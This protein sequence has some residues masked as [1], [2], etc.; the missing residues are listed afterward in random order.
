MNR[1][2]RN[3]IPSRLGIY[4]SLTLCLFL[5]SFLAAEDSFNFI[6]TADMRQYAG[7]EYDTSDY[8]LGVC[9]AIRG[10]GKGAFMVSPGDIDPPQGVR[11]TL[12]KV[13]G[14]DYLWY[15]VVGNHEAETPADMTWLREW[16]R[17]DIPNLVR[18]GPQNG[19]ETTY[20]F[21][22]GQVH[23]VVLNQYYDGSS[24]VGTNGDVVDELYAWLKTDLEANS[25]PITFVFGHEPIMPIADADNGR[26]RHLDDCLNA[27]QEN[28]HRFQVLLRKHKVRGLFVGHTH[29]YSAA[30]IN[31]LWQIDAGHCRGLGD[32]GAPSTFLKVSVQGQGCTV[33]VYRQESGG[34]GY[35]LTRT[36]TLD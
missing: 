16:G 7:P 32:K 9:E 5:P 24:D 31:G 12:D 21:D 35:R 27:H 29:N 13:F 3:I 11:Y 15:P 26:I 25:K 22:Y 33:D 4:V 1:P 19:T 23:F 18:R 28:N 17:G 20:S 34:K 10:V 36:V 30:K 8:F 2:I 6:V 14:A